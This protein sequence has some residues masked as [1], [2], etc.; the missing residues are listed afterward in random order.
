[1][2]PGEDIIDFE[3]VDLAIDVNILI[4]G[5]GIERHWVTKQMLI[6]A[7]YKV[8]TGTSTSTI[9]EQSK[10]LSLLEIATKEVYPIDIPEELPPMPL[11]FGKKQSWQQMNRG[12]MSKKQ[13][14][15]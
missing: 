9:E 15:K 11:N 14:R 13:R 6:D 3:R 4:L 8:H 7:G 5:G 12:T 10:T 2:A 1:M